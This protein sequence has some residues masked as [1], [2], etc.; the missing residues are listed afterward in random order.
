MPTDPVPLPGDYLPL[1]HGLHTAVRERIGSP[2]LVENELGVLPRQDVT[3]HI[4][5]TVMALSDVLQY[6]YEIFRDGNNITPNGLPTSF[7]RIA[8]LSDSN[9]DAVKRLDDLMHQMVRER[10][11]TA[12]A[13]SSK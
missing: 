7:V 3:E 10:H 4:V 9:R 6:S 1:A 13:K 12:L 5:H 8:E 11:A 2:R